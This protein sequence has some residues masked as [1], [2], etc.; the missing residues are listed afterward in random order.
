MIKKT[1]VSIALLTVACITTIS[2]TEDEAQLINIS[3]SYVGADANAIE[4]P[5]LEIF[6]PLNR[7]LVEKAEDAAKKTKKV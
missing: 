3:N 5:R 7:Y 6:E 2:F 4:L 1:S